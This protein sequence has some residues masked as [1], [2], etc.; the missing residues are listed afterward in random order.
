MI[1]QCEGLLK[2][3]SLNDYEIFAVRSDMLRAEAKDGK[4]H[5]L[6]RAA[7]AGVSI[8]LLRD[9]AMGF[10]YGSRVDANLVEAAIVSARHQFK[11]AHNHIPLRGD[12]P[13]VEVFDA[14][15]A[16]ASP[17]ECIARAMELEES[18][19]AADGR[20]Q[21]VRK[22][23]F[24]RGVTEVHIVNSQG[25]AVSHQATTCS[26]SLMVMAKDRDDM[27]S[28]YEYAFSHDWTDIDVKAV[29]RD[30]SGKAVAMLGARPMETTRL[31]VVF[32]NAT[33]A[34]MLEI[35]GEAFLGENVLKGKSY[36]QDKLGTACFSPA[37]T[38]ADNP[39]DVRASQACGFDGEGVPSRNN[40]LVERGVVSAFV[41]DSYWGRAAGKAST[42]NAVRGGYRSTPG[43]G[44]RHLC[45]APGEDLT[46]AC[47]GLGR[48][49][50]VTD[51]MGLH[52]ADPISGEFSVGVNGFLLDGGEILYPVREAALAGNIFAMFAQVLAVGTDVRAFGEVM[53][54]AILIDRMDISSK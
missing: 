52:T 20:V 50:K 18:A 15:I 46:S 12:V 4:V 30:A 22:A 39:L 54:P 28:G 14:R 32:D 48:I 11:D 24:A 29:G 43:L 53:C 42:G 6:D 44:L 2:E 27:Q 33:T 21:Q 13:P 5:S 9:G 16:A 41:Y 7:E 10:A 51:V 23:T 1:A 38:L 17:D 34:E 3:R 45:L 8:R 47:K 35:I 31:P 37:I 36:L 26:A 40:A 19:R 25:V 49:L